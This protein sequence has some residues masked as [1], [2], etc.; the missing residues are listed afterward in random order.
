MSSIQDI[1]QQKGPDIWSIGPE[2][3]VFDAIRL[4]DEKGIGALAVVHNEE[5]VGIIS[6]RDYTR[7]V[8]LKALVAELGH[9]RI[10][11]CE[12]NIPPGCI[13]N[14]QINTSGLRYYS[15]K[16]LSQVRF[17][18][19]A[20]KLGFSLKEIAALQIMRND[21]HKAKDNF[22]TLTVNKLKEVESRLEEMEFLKCKLQILLNLCTQESDNCGILESLNTDITQ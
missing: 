3:T 1:C 4:M 2:E 17:V 10:E 21:Q 22:R 16:A 14:L 15:E 13:S 8:A 9:E 6:E 19:R 11:W 20:Q 12:V 18:I 5:L 7:K